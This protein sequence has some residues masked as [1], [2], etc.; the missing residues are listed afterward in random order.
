MNPFANLSKFLTD[1]SPC[2]YRDDLI[3]YIDEHFLPYDPTGFALGFKELREKRDPLFLSHSHKYSE[4]VRWIAI[5]SFAG[6]NFELEPSP[7]RINEVI[8]FQLIICLYI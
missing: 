3:V 5:N 6:V 4:I 8:N 2:R 1:F 7:F